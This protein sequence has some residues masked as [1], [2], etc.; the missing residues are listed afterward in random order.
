M[1]A[2]GWIQ[3]KGGRRYRRRPYDNRKTLERSERGKRGDIRLMKRAVPSRAK[4]AKDESGRKNAI[5]PWDLQIPE[6]D[7]ANCI[8]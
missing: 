6:R 1:K 5:V 7:V 8:T 3:V 4:I 2:I